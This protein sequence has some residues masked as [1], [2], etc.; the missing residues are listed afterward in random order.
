MWEYRIFVEGQ[1]L[2]P[3]S[4]NMGL[5]TVKPR[6]RTVTHA[7]LEDPAVLLAVEEG[8]VELRLREWVEHDVQLWRRELREKLP[9]LQDTVREV[10]GVLNGD[11]NI[12]W[13]V[14]SVEDIEALLDEWKL[15]FRL[16]KVTEQRRFVHRD[17]LCIEHSQVEIAGQPFVTVCIRGTTRRRVTALCERLDL[18]EEAYVMNWAEALQELAREPSEG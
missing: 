1:Q 3:Q 11:P 5:E 6:E 10:A 7:L 13:P 9:F 8:L 12:T 17:R 4:L 2:G 16:V 14:E 15:A 18:P